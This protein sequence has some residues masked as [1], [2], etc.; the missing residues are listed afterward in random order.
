MVNFVFYVTEAYLLC[1]CR[2]A[3]L[4]IVSILRLHLTFILSLQATA[5]CLLNVKSFQPVV[6][7]SVGEFSYA[8]Y[9]NGNWFFQVFC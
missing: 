5:V 3:A 7:L 9:R 1:Y 2:L 4:R 6:V 8:I